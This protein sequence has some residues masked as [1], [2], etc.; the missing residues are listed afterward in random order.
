MTTTPA[1]Q[2]KIHQ[3][4]RIDC[5]FGLYTYHAL[6]GHVSTNKNEF[7]KEKQGPE[8]VTCGACIMRVRGGM[9]DP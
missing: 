7:R 5:T 9:R 1:Q 3:P 8:K 4:A 6:C 2:T